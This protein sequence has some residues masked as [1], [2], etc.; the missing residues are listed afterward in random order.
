[1]SKLGPE[2]GQFVE[3]NSSSFLTNV[4]FVNMCSL[5]VLPNSRLQSGSKLEV[6]LSHH[7]R[8]LVLMM[9]LMMMMMMQTGK[10]HELK[11]PNDNK[12]RLNCSRKHDVGRS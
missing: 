5:P 6:C 1:M 8:P 4:T 9:L 7:P 3:N 12:K 10:K 2:M 11:T